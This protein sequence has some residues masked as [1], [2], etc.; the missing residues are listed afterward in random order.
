MAASHCGALHTLLGDAPFGIGFEDRCTLRN[1]VGAL[2]DGVDP[3]VVVGV[4]LASGDRE[5][6]NDVAA[7][8][9]RETAASLQYW[10][11]LIVT[12]LP[13]ERS[14]AQTCWSNICAPRLGRS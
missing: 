9:G 11:R 10:R 5:A 12:S 6:S 2:R 8:V 3:L 1:H 13:V 4:E 7:G 14:T